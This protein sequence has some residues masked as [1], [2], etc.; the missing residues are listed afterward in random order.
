MINENKKPSSESVKIRM[1]LLN[2][3]FDELH[4]E[5]KS[6]NE[7]VKDAINN[8]NILFDN[9]Y[10]TLN[11]DKENMIPEIFKILIDSIGNSNDWTMFTRLAENIDFKRYGYN[12]FKK[13]RQNCT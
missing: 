6:W 13:F 9:Y 4:L 10:F 8:T 12:K 7:F 2:S 3:Q 11:D 5:Y 1:K